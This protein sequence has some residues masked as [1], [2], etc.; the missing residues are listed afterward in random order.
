MDRWL[1][2]YPERTLRRVYS[3]A[4]LS[5]HFV[6]R[7]DDV[8]PRDTTG[9]VI[10]ALGTTPI[11]QYQALS[12]PLWVAPPQLSEQ[13]RYPDRIHPLKRL[14]ASQ[15]QAVAQDKFTAPTAAAV[16]NNS[17]E[18]E[19]PDFARPKHGLRASLQQVFVTDY[20]TDALA[21]PPAP[22]LS[23]R[24]SFVDRHKYNR[25][26]AQFSVA[27]EEFG[28]IHQVPVMSWTGK[29]DDIVAR[30][31][32]SHAARSAG[33]A[34]IFEQLIVA[35][36]ATPMSWSPIYPAK[37][38]PKRRSLAALDAKSISPIYLAD[39]TVVAPTRSWGPT[40]PDFALAARR[41]HPG[42]Q[43]AWMMDRFAAPDPVT[44]PD[45]AA[46]V[47]VNIVYGR[48]P[49]I[50]RDQFVAPVFITDVTVTAPPVSWLAQYPDF[51]IRPE[52]L[53]AQQQ[54]EAS[55][56]FVP[57]VTA[58]APDLSWQGEYP[59]YIWRRRVLHASSNP[60][61]TFDAKWDAP[62]I[63][64]VSDIFGTVYIVRFLDG[65]VKA[66]LSLDGNVRVD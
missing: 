3:V 57:G 49:L 58:I 35:T 63:I 48:K 2:T 17:W 6:G 37:I 45:L 39:I 61:F 12:S 25:P 11:I 66:H 7:L 16:T 18:P 51:I 38:D 52:L 64:I 21:A 41:L 62:P 30:R 20:R 10:Y 36:P 26:L 47:Y 34:P 5:P 60:A 8:T 15:Q 33:M 56:I 59:D 50:E 23:W 55:P 31:K 54:I 65:N 32:S 22:D 24:P 40:Y 19:Y 1:P 27:Q 4:A 46:P 9:G 13:G 14:H 29:F 28:Y 44:A 42:S 43:P 53:T